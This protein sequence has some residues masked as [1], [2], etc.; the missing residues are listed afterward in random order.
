MDSDRVGDRVP[1]DV[2]GTRV[3]RSLTDCLKEGSDKLSVRWDEVEVRP[4][5]VFE[6]NVETEDI[7]EV[8]RRWDKGGREGERWRLARSE[9]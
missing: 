6:E 2:N 5:E 7:G 9:G 8:N 4:R 3:T 1:I